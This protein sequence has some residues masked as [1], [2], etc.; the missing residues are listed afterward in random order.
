MPYWCVT[1]RCLVE[2]EA[3]IELV[4]VEQDQPGDAAGLDL[5][6]GLELVRLVAGDQQQ[7]RASRTAPC[8][9]P[10]G[11]DALS[12][13]RAR[14]RSSGAGLKK[15]HLLPSARVAKIVRQR[16]A[17]RPRLAAARAWRSAAT[18]R[19]RSSGTSRR[20]STRPDR[21]GSGGRASRSRSHSRDRPSTSRPPGPSTSVA[22]PRDHQRSRTSV[23][24]TSGLRGMV[25]PRPVDRARAGGDDHVPGR[26]AGGAADRGDQVE[27]VAAAGDLRAFGRE[28]LDDPVRRDSATD[29]RHARARRSGDR[30]SSDS[31]TRSPPDRNSQREP[32]SPTAWPGSIWL[33]RSRSIGSLHGPS[34]RSAQM[35]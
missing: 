14:A 17:V 5:D 25:L 32:S 29:R 16:H 30:P 1:K 7:R 31:R 12:A 26:R 11:A 33:G 19:R 2:A 21:A 34:M 15:V 8:R 13:T 24:R 22:W 6:V 23:V 27:I 9:A 20:A 4:V 3:A 35:T 18:G 28:A 10:A